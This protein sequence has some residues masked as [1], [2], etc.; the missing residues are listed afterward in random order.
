[1]Q[2]AQIAGMEMESR[3]PTKNSILRDISYIVI[4]LIFSSMAL[5]ASLIIKTLE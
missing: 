3:V 2:C 5:N 1:M 4:Y